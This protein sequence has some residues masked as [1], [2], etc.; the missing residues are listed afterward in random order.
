MTTID[1][2]AAQAWT[3]L[4]MHMSGDQILHRDTLSR[5]VTYLSSV[6]AKTIGLPFTEF[7]P[8][9]ILATLSLVVAHKASPDEVARDNA[10]SA[11]ARGFSWGPS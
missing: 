7:D 10:V 11:C 1:L 9:R 4:A 3:R 5:D 8:S 6:A 2:L